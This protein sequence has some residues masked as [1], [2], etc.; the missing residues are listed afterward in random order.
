MLNEVRLIGNLGKD[1]EIRPD[2][3]G[4]SIASFSIATSERWKDKATGEKRERTEWHNIVVFGPLAGIVEKY[5]KKGSKLMVGGQLRTRKWQDQ[6]GNDRYSTEVV[7][8]GFNA[9]LL[10]LGDAGGGGRAQG[11]D[12]SGY[13]DGPGGGGAAQMAPDL[14][15][16]VPF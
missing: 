2:K 12:Y 11:G 9:T 4:E 1:P 6:S 5:A 8:S 3:R 10:L 14:D 16:D 7:L 13:Q 15:D